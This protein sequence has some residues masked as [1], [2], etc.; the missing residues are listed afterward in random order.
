MQR[1]LAKSGIK[2]SMNGGSNSDNNN[3]LG[4]ILSDN[5]A[6]SILGG[7]LSGNLS[8]IL[9]SLSI[10]GAG[11]TGVKKILDTINGWSQQGF[12]AINTLSG[13]LLSYQGIKEGLQEAGAI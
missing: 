13:N 2:L 6:E 5:K 8:R 11:I 9:G 3:S 7:I 10:V 4:G 12:N 1:T